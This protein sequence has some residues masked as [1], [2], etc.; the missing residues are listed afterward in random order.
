VW[1]ASEL[2]YVSLKS[3]LGFHLGL[4][5]EGAKGTG[6]FP[7]WEGGGVEGVLVHDMV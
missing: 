3:H 4:C 5:W 1:M 6:L 2:C 7:G